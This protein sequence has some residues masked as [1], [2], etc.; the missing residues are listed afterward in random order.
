MS[1]ICAY[2]IAHGVHANMAT[3]TKLPS[4]KVRA[5]VRI[6][7]FYRAQTFDLEK[8]ARKWAKE[9]EQQLKLSTNGD[10][11]DPPKNANF[12]DLV[13]VYEEHVG[14]VKAFGKNKKAVLKSLKAK[15]GHVKLRALSE[16]V[17]RDFVDRRVKEGA[18]GVTIA[19]DLAY[20]RAVLSWARYVRN[21][22]LDPDITLDVRRSLARRGLK[23]R[24]NERTRVASPSELSK[25]CEHYQK[26][27]RNTIDMI[28]VIEFALLTS[29]RQ[30]EICML[31]IEDID[32]E[33]RVM[34]VRDRK[35]P[36]EKMGNHGEVPVL[37]D[38]VEPINK[39]IDGRE[40]GRLFPYAPRSVSA[41]FTRACKA[42][43]IEDLRFHDLRHT[44][45]TDLFTRELDIESVSLFTGHKDWKMLRRYTH[46]KAESVHLI[47]RRKA[48]RRAGEDVSQSGSDVTTV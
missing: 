8:N 6:G 45:A 28:A 30:E 41:S 13:S 33:R 32:L 2:R 29:L 22:N 26:M 18:G 42:T 37:D 19:V 34:L 12:E 25:L 27:K 24:S 23:V 11:I 9:I 1:I 36:T 39:A 46:I 16:A 7:G 38:F 35:H 40:T 48:F 4:G 43:G 47:E 3:F 5:Q 31:R 17:V 21:L 44:A 20:L 15:I 14:G 10:Y